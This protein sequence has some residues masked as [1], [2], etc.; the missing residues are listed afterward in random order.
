M[1][2]VK[3]NLY[4]APTRYIKYNNEYVSCI[5]IDGIYTTIE[6]SKDINCAIQVGFSEA[7]KLIDFMCKYYM[8]N[9]IDFSIC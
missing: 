9:T 1:K 6:T 5:S 2:N 7:Y 4:S 3:P 8:Y